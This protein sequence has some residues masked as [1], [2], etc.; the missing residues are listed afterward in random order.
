MPKSIDVGGILFVLQPGTRLWVGRWEAD[1]RD[2][3]RVAHEVR[4]AFRAALVHRMRPFRLKTKFRRGFGC[5][6]IIE[7]AVEEI[8]R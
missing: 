5:D 7:V 4:S 2:Q 8:N 3:N 6:W 1:D